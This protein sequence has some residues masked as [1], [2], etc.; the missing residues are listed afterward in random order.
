MHWIVLISPNLTVFKKKPN[1]NPNRNF[2][3][4]L[5]QILTESIEIPIGIYNMFLL[6]HYD[7][8]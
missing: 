6:I 3:W 1:R 4:K 2:Y 8:L 7:R 5:A